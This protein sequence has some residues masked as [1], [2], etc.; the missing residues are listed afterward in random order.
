MFKDFCGFKIAYYERRLALGIE[1]VMSAP[2]KYFSHRK[3][4]MGGMAYFDIAKTILPSIG[5]NC[6]IWLV[7][8]RE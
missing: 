8:I 2:N 6:P 7:G 1:I 4:A 3:R 5:L